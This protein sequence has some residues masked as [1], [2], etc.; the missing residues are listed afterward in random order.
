MGRISSCL[1]LISIGLTTV[2]SITAIIISGWQVKRIGAIFIWAAIYL[3]GQYTH[4]V[5][6]LNPGRFDAFLRVKGFNDLFGIRHG[7]SF[8]S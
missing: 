6:N 7:L 1:I 5:I 4:P 8:K 2:C 3:Y